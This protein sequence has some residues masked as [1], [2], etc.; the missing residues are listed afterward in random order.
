MS[1]VQQPSVSIVIPARNEEA[2][3]E[4][5]LASLER[6]EYSPDKLEVII[7]NDGSTDATA[8]II[9]KYRRPWLTVLGTGGVGPSRGRNLGVKQARG[10]YVAFTDADCVVDKQWLNELLKGFSEGVA[11]VGG[12]Q[13]IPDD[14]S[15]FERR[16]H[17]FLTSM[18]FVAEYVKTGQTIRPVKDFAS[19]NGMYLKSAL[20]EVGG[21]DEQLWPGEDVELNYK[22]VRRGHK[23]AYNPAA[24]VKH[25]R[26]RTLRGFYRMMWRYGWSQAYLTRKYGFF[27]KLQYEPVALL[28]VIAAWLAVV[29]F[30]LWW[31]LILAGAVLVAAFIAFLVGGLRKGPGNFAMFLV[32]MVAWNL[33]FALNLLG[34]K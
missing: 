15:P 19:C 34:R 17:D 9:G 4:K 21:F 16:I 30:S 28:V 5:C 3:I 27:R 6:L 11:G 29:V 20:N 14:A 1:V 33:G 26:P 25:H 2:I 22:I 10:E 7:I 18:H 8:A 12:S 31:G 23:L 32:T 13:Q 24:I